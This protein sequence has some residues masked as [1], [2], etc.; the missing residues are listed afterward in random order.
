MPVVSLMR[1][2]PLKSCLTRP[3]RRA[4]VLAAGLTVLSALAGCVSPQP[5][6]AMSVP[7]PVLPPISEP[8]TIVRSADPPPGEPAAPAPV[9]VEAWV[10]LAVGANP[11]LSKAAFAVESARGRFDQA[12]LYPN[13]TVAVTADELGDRTGPGGI[14][15]APQVSQEIVTGGK[16]S[17]SQAVAAREVDQAALAL[18]RERYAVIGSVRSR[19][20]RS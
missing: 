20:Y 8:G 3:G 2:V 10:Q 6:P 7:A 9:G 16:L 18:L 14:I 11:R 5:R 4:A 1:F 17:L 19:A 13:P 15:T 12:G